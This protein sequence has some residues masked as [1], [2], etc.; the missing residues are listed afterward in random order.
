MNKSLLF[1][2]LS[3]SAFVACEGNGGNDEPDVPTELS[4][5]WYAGGKLGTAFNSSASAYEQ[6]TPV[7]ENSGMIQSFKNGELLFERDF[8]ENKDGAFSGLGPLMVRRG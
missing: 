2:S 8:N 5:E 7:I 1:L 3:L 4:D 6:P